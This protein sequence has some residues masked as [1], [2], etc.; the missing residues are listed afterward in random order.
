MRLPELVTR[1]SRGVPESP[2]LICYRNNEAVSESNIPYPYAG[3]YIPTSEFSSGFW[4]S[5]FAC[6]CIDAEHVQ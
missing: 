6:I 5:P 4:F 3:L 1:R 2:V